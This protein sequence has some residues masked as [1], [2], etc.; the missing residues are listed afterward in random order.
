LRLRDKM[1]LNS[2]LKNLNLQPLQKDC[3]IVGINNLKD[4]T[5]QQLSFF[6]KEKHLEQLQ[7]TEAAAVFINKKYIDF[8]PQNAQ[9]IIVE[10]PYLYLAYASKYFAHSFAPPT[11]KPQI[12]KNCNIYDGVNFGNNV[13]IGNNV[14]LMPGCY[15]GDNVKIS[16]N[17]FLHPNV[18]IYHNCVIGKEVI[19][20]SG[21]VIGSDGYGFATQ[22]DGTH[23][24]IYQNG[25]VVVEDNVEIGANVTIDRAVF[26]STVIQEGTKLDN[27]IHIAHNCIVGKNNFFAAQVGLSGSTTTGNN[28]MMGG[29]VGTAGHLKIADFSVIA[30]RGGVTKDVKK[31]GYYAGFPLMEGKLW[32]K[33]QAKLARLIK[34]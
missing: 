16:D 20:H 34:G 29:Q 17:C 11:Q 30:A 7:N 26:T 9:A 1:T 10:D 18:V 28:V 15:I 14:T 4:A 2:L 23:V 5:P 6:N 32:L 8:L 25:N 31:S 33:L 22:P 19:I 24:K 12:G 21:S 3:E 13:S 27:L